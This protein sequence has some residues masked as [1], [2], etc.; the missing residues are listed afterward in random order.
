MRVLALFIYLTVS[1]SAYKG[2][3]PNQP[4]MDAM[5]KEQRVALVI[6][7]KEYD[8]ALPRLKNP[9]ND[10]RLMKK[11]LKE[12]GFDIIYAQNTSAITLKNKFN[13][14][15]K[16]ISQGGVGLFYF[17]GH[18]IEKN[19]K[20]YLIP[21]DTDIRS[22]DDADY[23]TLPLN[24]VL[25]DM[26]RAK[27][28]LNIVLVDACRNNP[29]FKG[30]SGLSES[31]EA[32]GIYIVYATAPGKSALDGTA[33]NSPF[34]LG[35]KKHINE[36]ISIEQMFKKVTRHVYYST[37][38]RQFPY[39]RSGLLG[40]FYF[41][42]PRKEIIYGKEKLCLERW[43]NAVFTKESIE[44]QKPKYFDDGVNP[45]SKI[46]YKLDGLSF[47]IMYSNDYS[48]LLEKVEMVDKYKNGKSD[49]VYVQQ[50][51]LTKCKK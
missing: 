27:N 23:M 5:Q 8:G 15:I 25:G 26:Q 16:K 2:V 42:L 37:N 41:T 45:K 17:S 43:T 7:N 35:I 38:E 30:G 12:K 39:T 51:L 4:D 22:I 19:S 13:Q 14:F 32:K 9:I 31:K 29:F 10:A 11:I 40:D 6:G 24:K 47:N 28:R 1:L 44:N 20:N 3:K 33:D 21:V 49:I 50:S 34:V 48:I 18:G 46:F 36:S